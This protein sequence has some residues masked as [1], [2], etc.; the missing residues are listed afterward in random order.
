GARVE[1]VTD[2]V[3]RTRTA[4][5][6]TA[7]HRLYGLVDG[8][9]LWAYDMAAQGQPLQSHLSARLEAVGQRTG[10]T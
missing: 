1:L 4:K 5:E 10:Q 9:L 6:V 2:V 3:A 7:G 8:D